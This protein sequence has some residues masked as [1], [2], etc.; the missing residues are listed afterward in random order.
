M[1]HPHWF[2]TKKSLLFPTALFESEHSFL[3]ASF[4]FY[5]FE[6]DL[7]KNKSCL[8]EGR[9][10]NFSFSSY[11]SESRSSFAFALLFHSGGFSDR[12]GKERERESKKSISALWR[13]A[14]AASSFL[15]LPFLLFFLPLYTY[16][17]AL[18]TFL[19]KYNVMAPFPLPS[20]LDFGAHNANSLVTKCSFFLLLFPA[21]KYASRG[22]VKKFGREKKNFPPPLFLPSLSSR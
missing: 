2:R 15:L 1:P 19:R 22:S 14:A 3:H 9:G 11:V 13:V 18:K 20:Q 10:G 8:C 21:L 5:F 6:S 4:A 16:T 17:E 7:E 12:P